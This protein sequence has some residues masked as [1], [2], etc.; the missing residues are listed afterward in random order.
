V[1]RPRDSSTPS[2]L[3]RAGSGENSAPGRLLR[4]PI[5]ALPDTHRQVFFLQEIEKFEL[6]ETAKILNIKTFSIM[7]NLHRA[8]MLP[9]KIPRTT[10]DHN[11]SAG[12]WISRTSFFAIIALEPP[13][14]C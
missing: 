5:E 14:H 2:P 1:K 4:Q 7:A 12:T 8:R 6:R 13:S 3:E 11:R 9:Q 10:I